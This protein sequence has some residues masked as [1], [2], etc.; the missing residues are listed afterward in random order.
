MLYSKKGIAV[1]L[2][3]LITAFVSYAAPSVPLGITFYQNVSENYANSSFSINWTPVTNENISNYSIYIYNSASFALKASNTSDL[4]YL[5]SEISNSVNYTF[6]ISAV[7]TTGDEGPNATSTWIF[8]DN[9]F[10]S[11]ALNSPSDGAWDSDGKVN[12]T[13]TAIDNTILNCSLW[14]NTTGSWELNMTNSSVANNTATAFAFD[15]NNLASSADYK[16]SVQCTDRGT[17][18]AWANNYTFRVSTAPDFIIA[19]ITVINS[20]NTYHPDRP[21]PSG[22]ITL[23]ITVKNNGTADY[24]SGNINV[25][26]LWNENQFN[27]TLVS[28]LAQGESFN[29]INEIPASLATEGAHIARAKIDPQNS[30]QETDEAN[31]ELARYV[32]T[33]LNVTVINITPQKPYQNESLIANLSIRYQDGDLATGISMANFTIFDYYIAGANMVSVANSS[34]LTYSNGNYWFNITAPLKNATTHRVNAGAHAFRFFIKDN[35]T[36]RYYDNAWIINNAINSTGNYYE[37]Q[38]PNLEVDFDGFGSSIDIRYAR[39]A[40]FNVRVKNNGTTNISQINISAVSS[41]AGSLTIGANHSKGIMC[42]YNSSDLAP[43]NTWAV[44]CSPV[45]NFSAIGNY[46]ITL[47]ARGVDAKGVFYN[48]TSA[49]QAINVYNGSGTS[50]SD[51]DTT[52]PVFNYSIE[53][54][55][56]N[57]TVFAEQGSLTSIKFYIKNAGN[58]T[59]DNITLSMAVAEKNSFGKWYNSSKIR[60]IRSLNIGTSNVNITIPENTTIMQ[61]TITASAAGVQAGTSKT[62]TFKLYVIPG[63]K[64][65]KSISEYIGSVESE[66][67]EINSTILSLMAKS[68]SINITIASKKLDEIARLIASS[69]DAISKGDYLS[70]YNFQT[71]ISALLSEVKYLVSSEKGTIESNEKT[72]KIIASIALILLAIAGVVYYLWLPEEGYTPG[73]GYVFR[74]KSNSP[75]GALQEQLKKYVRMVAGTSKKEMQDT[76]Y[77]AAKEQPYN[78]SANAGNIS[79]KLKKMINNIIE[80]LKKGKEDGKPAYN[81]HKKQTWSND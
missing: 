39:N 73:K 33:V 6:N 22:N 52:N 42:T 53:F 67:D 9:S 8:V 43:T 29:W 5:F 60:E 14:T 64:T 78:F 15:S 75:L 61:Y 77:I 17:N 18:R 79:A 59:V 55:Q 69:R 76:K 65:K 32:F 16:W 4:G 48:S 1:L 12:F 49:V 58:G 35:S 31:N 36:G 56:Y 72:Q 23:N 38:A 45:F 51:T 10:P 68:E 47:M 2:A 46:S 37:L 28:A 54:Y 57:K 3:L 81:F 63:A 62:V 71:D 21:V 27:S 41:L 66:L 70:A 25:S 74:P 34:A 20:S 50:S 44:A 40:A 13:F 30:I 80:Q 24:S 7:N 19:N 26:L 11:I